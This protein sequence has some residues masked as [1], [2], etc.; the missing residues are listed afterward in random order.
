MSSATLWG[1]RYSPWTEK[2]CWALDHHAVDYRY[3]EHKPLLGEPALRWRTRRRP[4]GQPASVPV[5]I[6]DR[7]VILESLDIARYAERIGSGA[8]LF[9]TEREREILHWCAASDRA[10]QCGRALVVSAIAR[11]DEACIESLPPEIPKPLR[12]AMRGVARYGANFIAR[13]Y[14]ADQN[15]LAENQAQLAEFCQRLVDALAGRPYLLG[16]LSYADLSCA[17]VINGFAP[18]TQRFFPHSPAT[19][20]AWT[21][22]E[23]VDR[24][25]PLVEW[26]DR[27]YAEHR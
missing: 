17:V 6:A 10:M 1:L 2:T 5:L 22:P 3:R 13:K 19:A 9:E 24:F 4:A 21:V 11:S 18:L 7:E 16:S 25:H 27:L 23:L 8:P 26:R 12:P 14:G 15:A 20:Q